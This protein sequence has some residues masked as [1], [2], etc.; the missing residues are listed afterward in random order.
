MGG[1]VSVPRV[2]SV[3]QNVGGATAQNNEVSITINI[4]SNGNESVETTAQQG[5]QLG[6]LIQ[7]K[8]LE[9][10]AKERRVGGMLA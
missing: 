4:D 10:L 6:N 3:Y 5:K 1:G 9:V 2:S 7:A 8:V